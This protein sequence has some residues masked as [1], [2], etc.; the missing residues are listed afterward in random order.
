MIDTHLLGGFALAWFLLVVVPGPSV[1][2]V[3]SRGVALGRR[4]A[5]LTVVGNEAGIL[6]QVSLVAAGI[7]SIV[8]RS[9]LV[10]NGLKLA[11]AVYLVYLG[12]QAVRHRKMLT[13]A[14]EGA[15]IPKPAGRI[16]REGFFV[17]VTNPKG[18]VFFTAVLPQFVDPDRSS[19]PLQMLVLGVVAAAIAMASDSVWGLVAGSARQ[20]LSRSPRRLEALGGTGGVV[21]I[22]LGVRL[23]VSGRHD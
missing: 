11:G 18:I 14:F 5:L 2:F 16:V 13:A 8:E 19:V 10:F 3:I 20:W 4:A 15:A 22:G 1:L 6:V 9:V 23:A 12:I 21:M 7:G 17:G